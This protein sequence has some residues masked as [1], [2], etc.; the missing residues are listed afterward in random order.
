MHPPLDKPEQHES[1]GAKAVSIWNGLPKPIVGLAPMDGVTDAAFRTITAR[2]GPP[3]ITFTE[4]VSIDRIV[5]GYDPDLMELRYDEIE[6]PVI[7]QIFGTDPEAFYQ[8][9]HL[10]CELGFDG[11]D[12]NM[13]CPAKNV[14][15]AGAGAGLIRTPGLAREILRQTRQGILDWAA[16]QDIG[17]IGLPAVVADDVRRARIRWFGHSDEQDRRTPR[18][19]IPV[20]VKTRLGYHRVDIEEWIPSLLSESPAAITLHGRTLSQNYSGEADWDAI[21]RAAGIIR[22]SG[23]LILGNG[24]IRSPAM[25]VGRIRET[26][27]DGVLI[28][29]AAMGNP[30]I[31]RS[32]GSIRAAVR[33]GG[34]PEESCVHTAEKLAVALEHAEVFERYRVKPS[35]RAVRKHL[36]AY[37]SGFPNASELR[38]RLVRAETLSE[39]DSILQPVVCN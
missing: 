13:G 20:S 16:G 30:W 10:I 36:A 18:L 15:R 8:T 32:C 37:C 9:A 1:I 21:A 7:A 28:G 38:R 33:F 25:A 31:F 11:I 22:G 12:I 2:H 35:L 6:R 19:A 17:R 39:L 5:S 23:T 29:R 34:T 27:V 4:F 3:D 24:D 14:A 26:G